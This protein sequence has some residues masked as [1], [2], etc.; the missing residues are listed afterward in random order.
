[1]GRN[2]IQLAYEIED[3]IKKYNK[4]PEKKVKR[5]DIVNMLQN[6]EILWQ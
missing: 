2:N 6:A 3:M 4:K 1:M 5:K